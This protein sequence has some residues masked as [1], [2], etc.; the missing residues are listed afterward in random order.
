M[1]LNTDDRAALEALVRVSV[2]RIKDFQMAAR[3]VEA[4]A[5]MRGEYDELRQVVA[6]Y[7]TGTELL[8]IL[9]KIDSIEID[10]DPLLKQGRALGAEIKPFTARI[11]EAAQSIPLTVATVEQRTQSTTIACDVEL[12]R[13]AVGLKQAPLFRLWMILLQKVRESNNG[14]VSRADLPALLKSYGVKFSERN[15]RRWLKKGQGLYWQVD[16]RTGRI[17]HTGYKLLSCRLV[18]YALEIGLP[19]LVSTNRPGQRRYMYIDVSGDHTIDFEANVYASWLASKNDPSIARDTVAALFNRDP[20]ALR[21]WDKVAG[22]QPV[23]NWAQYH[24]NFSNA[25]P[26]DTDG[27]LREDVVEYTAK[28]G[29]QWRAQMVNT[30]HTPAIKQHDKRGQSRRVARVVR[31]L[32]E[33]IEPAGIYGQGEAES[34]VSSGG[35]NPTGRLYFSDHKRARASAKH[36]G[37]KPRFIPLGASRGTTVWDYS[38][39][40]ILHTELKKLQPPIRMPQHSDKNMS[41]VRC[42]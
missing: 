1:A 8:T 17:H 37:E 39:D 3:H 40:G 32:L 41:E 19:D 13:L 24:S 20:R 42:A 12:A 29:T 34:S 6:Q 2:Q 9:Q 18:S 15:L 14:H 31:D 27:N 30:Y 33:S 21:Q 25:V 11:A 26:Q 4:F 10:H 5:T 23:A 22:V 16:S 7:F 28:S 38:P 36:N 35:L